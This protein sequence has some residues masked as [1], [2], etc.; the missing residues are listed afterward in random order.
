MIFSSVDLPA[1]L[2]PMMATFAPEPISRLMSSS[3]GAGVVA[4]PPD[5]ARTDRG[6][7]R[8]ASGTADRACSRP[9]VDAGAPSGPAAGRHHSRRRSATAAGRTRRQ[10]PRRS[11]RRA[12]TPSVHK[13][14]N[15]DADERVPERLDEIGHRVQVHERRTRAGTMSREKAIGDTNISSRSA[16]LIAAR[17]RAP[18]HANRREATRSSGRTGTSPDRHRQ[19]QEVPPM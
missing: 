9:Q 15:P 7:D 3:A 11:D 13:G 12:Q 2:R 19:I 17:R 4:G 14:R 18:G 6:S 5:R 16:M 10:P 1:P 8:P